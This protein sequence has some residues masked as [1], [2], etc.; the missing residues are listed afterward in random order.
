MSN[1]KGKLKVSATFKARVVKNKP[2]KE[3]VKEEVKQK[4]K[5]EKG[6]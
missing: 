5:K 3:E 2:P 1:I 6:E 4:P